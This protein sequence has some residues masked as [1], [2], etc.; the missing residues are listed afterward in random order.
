MCGSDP[1]GKHD[2]AAAIVN[3]GTPRPE[4]GAR[5]LQKRSDQ[6]TR[7]LSVSDPVS[8]RESLRR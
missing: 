4:G 6:P 3:H 7:M 5:A 1:R 2:V 8:V